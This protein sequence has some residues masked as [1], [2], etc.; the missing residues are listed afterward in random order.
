MNQLSKVQSR[1]ESVKNG[2][3]QPEIYSSFLY[4]DA[5]KRRKRGG[6]QKNPKRLSIYLEETYL[7]G[8]IKITIMPHGVVGWIKLGKI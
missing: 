6:K 5:I 3:G 4:Q 7:L 2:S 8:K 1:A